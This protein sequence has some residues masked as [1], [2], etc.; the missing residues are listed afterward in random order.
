MTKNIRIL[1]IAQKAGVSIGTV[2][3][4]LH[5]RGE[6]SDETRDKILEIIREFDYRPNILASSLASKKT[7]TFA[8]LTPWALDKDSFWS[9]PQEGID[10]AVNNLRQFG[11]TLQPFHFKMEDPDSFTREANRLLEL[12][13]DGILLAP[14]GKGESLKFTE[15]LDKQSI[16]YVFIDSNLTEANP[17]SFVVQ[18]SVQSGFL[19]GKLLDYG[20]SPKSNILMIHI[21]KNLQNANHLLQRERG[22]LNYFE[23]VSHKSHRVIKMEVVSDELLKA[24][25]LNTSIAKVNSIDAVFVT[26]SKVHLIAGLFEAYEIRPKIIGY[27]LIPKNIELLQ[28]GKIDFLLNQNPE[29]QG[30]SATNLLF[31]KVVRKEKVNEANYTAIDI[32]TK[33][34]NEYYNSI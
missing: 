31:D 21:T 3:R 5:Q 14:W 2:D 7:I 10:K 27:D 34:N 28:Q 4:V 1:D 9:K 26:N 24:T 33:E 19:A 6:V 11:I 8:S 12:K 25:S 17:I 29:N 30:Y 18:D 16:P 20:I 22:F 32:I 13:P 23:T 15:I